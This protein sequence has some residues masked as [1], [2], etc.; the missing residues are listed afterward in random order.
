MGVPTRPILALLAVLALPG[1]A[2]AGDKEEKA[3]SLV[4]TLRKAEDEAARKGL[5]ALGW[6]PSGYVQGLQGNMQMTTAARKMALEQPAS[7]P[8]QAQILRLPPQNDSGL[9]CLLRTNR[10]VRGCE[11]APTVG[12]EYGFFGCRLRM[13]AGYAAC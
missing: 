8:P 6:V 11:S 5:F 3:R 2:A 4:A 1:L 10:L 13:T 12:L 7:R 9:R